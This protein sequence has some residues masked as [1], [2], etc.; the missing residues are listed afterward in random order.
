MTVVNP[1]P[2]GHRNVTPYP[3]RA[4]PRLTAAGRL[5][6]PVE[7]KF[8][9]DRNGTIEDPFGHRWYVSTRIEDVSPA[10]IGR[11]AAQAIEAAE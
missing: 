3:I 8:H 4:A 10:E 2:D 6:H 1:I 7:D 5:V 9:G 11:R